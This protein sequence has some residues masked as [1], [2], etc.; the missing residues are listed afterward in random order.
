MSSRRLPIILVTCLA[1]TLAEPRDGG[2]AEPQARIDPNGALLPPGAIARLGGVPWRTHYPINQMAFIP[3]GKYLVTKSKYQVTECDR[4]LSVWDLQTGR[5]V[6]TISS[7]G[8]TQGDGFADGFAFTPDGKFRLSADEPGER[9]PGGISGDPRSTSRLHLW[10]Y[11]TGK[12][13]KRSPDL[14]TVPNCLAIRPDGCGVAYATYFGD[15]FLWDLQKNAFRRVIVGD[16]RTR[17]HSL[18]FT[19]DGKHLVVL[20]SEGGVSRRIDVDSGRVL[21][22]VDLGSCGRLALAP[23]DGTIATYSYPDRLYLYD[24]LTGERRRLPLKDK[25]GYLDLSFS[26]DGR[27]LLAQ[28]RSAEVVQFWDTAK[29][30]LLRRLRVSGWV[31]KDGNANELQLSANGECLA[32]YEDYYE[33]QFNKAALRIWDA[34]TGQPQLCFPHRISPPVRL[35]F[36]ADGKEVVSHA[37]R[38]NSPGGQFSR[39]DIAK[40]KLLT[41]IFPDAPREKKDAAPYDWQLAPDGQHLAARVGHVIYLYEG[42]TGKRLALSDKVPSDSD[43]T[44][45]PDGRA[46]LMIDA[47]KDARL[48]DVTT[49][50]LLRRVE[51]KR[52]GGLFSWPSPISFLRLTPDGKTLVEGEGWRKVHLQDAATGKL[53]ATITL[54]EEREPYD[55]NPVR[56]ETAFTPDSRYL[57]ASNT[58]NFWIWDLVAGKEIGPFEQ[59]KRG[60]WR[61][62]ESDQVAV[63]PDGGLVA[64]FDDARRLRLYEV[65]TGRIVYRF[66]EDYSSIAFAPSG[67]RLATGCKADASVLIWD[68]PLLFRSQLLSSKNTS[69]ESLWDVLASDDAVQAHRAL[70]RLAALP[71]ADAFLARHLKLVEAVPPERLR[72]LLADLG[73]PDFGTRERAEQALAAAGEPVRAAI[74]EALAGTKDV[75]VRRRLLSLQE[76]LHPQ[77]LE[78]LRELRAVLVLE[79]RG[80]AEARRV[81]ERLAAGLSEARLTQEAKAALKRLPK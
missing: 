3:G 59:D 65:C 25:V 40:G 70:W 44:F 53:R 47:D 15:V 67:W 56:W 52:K 2:A 68:L 50:K 45:T 60:R 79:S 17:M 10:D 16:R 19:G 18:S 49:G 22:M 77:S 21:K 5:V 69:A 36:S 81:L 34:R 76:R 4:S 55:Y 63:S 30:Q 66:P 80:T 27:T 24:S 57:F 35:A 31:G 48:W 46:I 29:G 12:L 7:D 32:S 38:E 26:P 8:T 23:H 13:L 62:F 74:G 20:P 58:R 75:E 9:T 43:W 41:R 71:D 42:S 14:G 78:R 37:H 33:E 39:W 6:R 73:S 61:L 51:L 54:P 28:D 64:W 11:S 1:L 72:A